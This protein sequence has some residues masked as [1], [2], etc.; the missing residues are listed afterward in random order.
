MKVKELI[1][2]LN[3]L[4]Q[5]QK[6]QDVFV[7]DSGWLS[8]DPLTTVETVV[9]QPVNGPYGT[10]WYLPEAKLTIKGIPLPLVT[11]IGLRAE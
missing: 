10:G 1:E 4:P 5:E 9:L 8:Y 2:T 7:W 11:A 6:E 3:N